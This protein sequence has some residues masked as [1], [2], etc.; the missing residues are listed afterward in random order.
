MYIC[1]YILTTLFSSSTYVHGNTFDLIMSSNTNNIVT[2]HSIGPIFSDFF[3]I[4][5]THSHPKPIRI[6]TTKISRKLHN[7]SIPAFISIFLPFQPQRLLNSIHLSPQPLMNTLP[8][9]LKPP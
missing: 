8:Y 5:L 3:F 9:S 2:N 1:I 7:L 6:I 4:F